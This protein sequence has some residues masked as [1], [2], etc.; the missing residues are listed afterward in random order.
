MRTP[1]ANT[2]ADIAVGAELLKSTF[3]FDV[4]DCPKCHGRM[5]LL[6]MLTDAKSVARY[7]A[8]LGEPTDVPGRCGPPYW[9]SAVLRV[10]ALAGQA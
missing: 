8:K 6:A 2:H 10:K 4:L 5:K 9:K 7:L 3:D 1:R